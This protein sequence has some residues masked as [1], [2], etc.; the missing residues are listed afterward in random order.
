MSQRKHDTPHYYTPYD[1]GEDSGAEDTGAEDTGSEMSGSDEDYD[2]SKLPDY[3]DARIRREEDPRYAIYRITG[4]NFDTFGEQLDYRIHPHETPYSAST[5]IT[6]LAGLQYLNPPKTVTTSL[7]SIKSTNRDISVYPSP[8]YFS[9]KTPR[10]YKNVTK[11][12]L[13]QI[14]FPN[15]NDTMAPTA[16]SS[17]PLLMPSLKRV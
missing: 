14:S 9:I 6:S 16:P 2:D 17:V 8:F 13:V 5:N 12:Q 7:F 15:T 11:F 1:S 3:E 4:P 10:V